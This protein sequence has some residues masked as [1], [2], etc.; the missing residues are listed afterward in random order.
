LFKVLAVSVALVVLAVLGAL[1]VRAAMQV[2]MN[3]DINRILF[4]AGLGVMEAMGG[5]AERLATAAVAV[6]SM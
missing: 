4:L 3:P 1:V 6:L 2:L 5:M